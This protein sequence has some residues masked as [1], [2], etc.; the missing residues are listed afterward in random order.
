[1]KAF[2]PYVLVLEF[3]RLL[4]PL[5]SFFASIVQTTL[6]YGLTLLSVLKY[7]WLLKSYIRYCLWTV[8]ESYRPK[9]RIYGLSWAAIIATF[10]LGFSA[11]LAKYQQEKTISR[12]FQKKA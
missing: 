12:D 5:R 7:P 4:F 11:K 10:I 2:Y 9:V 1:V 8:S 6:P 3:G